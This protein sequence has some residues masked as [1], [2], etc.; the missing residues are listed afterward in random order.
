MESRGRGKQM[1]VIRIN[2]AVTVQD[3]G[4]QMKRVGGTEIDHRASA[5]RS[6]EIALMESVPPLRDDRAARKARV[7]VRRA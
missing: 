5:S 7:N 6:S 4:R 2:D 3:C 1:R